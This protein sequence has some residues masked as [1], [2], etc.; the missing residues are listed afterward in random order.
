MNDPLTMNDPQTTT[1]P[2]EEEADAASGMFMRFYRCDKF[3]LVPTVVALVRQA[4]KLR[5]TLNVVGEDSELLRQLDTALWVSRGFM[6]HVLVSDQPSG[7]PDFF[8]QQPAL[9]TT[10][11]DRRNAPTGIIGVNG[12][13][14]EDVHALMGNDKTAAHDPLALQKGFVVFDPTPPE[15]ATRCRGLWVR[16]GREGYRAVLHEHREGKWIET[17]HNPPLSS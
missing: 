3:L 11:L 10:S 4:L 13:P 9:L 5:M 1:P 12:F 17:A 2:P 15:I 8:A 6:P 7:S 16:V 14:F